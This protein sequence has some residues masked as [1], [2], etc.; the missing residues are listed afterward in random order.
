VSCEELLELNMA[1]LHNR[2]N[3]SISTPHR[4]RKELIVVVAA[5]SGTPTSC[6]TTSFLDH[7][8]PERRAQ[9]PKANRN[10]QMRL[11]R[12]ERERRQNFRFYFPFSIFRFRTARTLTV[13]RNRK[14]EN[15]GGLA[16]CYTQRYGWMGLSRGLRGTVFPRV[17]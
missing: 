6:P 4:C 7:R 2:Y 15:G 13:K 9:K 16:I 1:L 5:S 14:T 10:V 17:S 8:C 3:T 11:L 12:P